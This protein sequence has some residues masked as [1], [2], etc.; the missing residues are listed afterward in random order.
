[1]NARAEGM[2]GAAAEGVCVQQLLP[3]GKGKKG[4]DGGQQHWPRMSE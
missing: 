1:M 4:R 2:A 3:K